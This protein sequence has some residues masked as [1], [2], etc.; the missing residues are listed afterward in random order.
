MDSFTKFTCLYGQPNLNTTHTLRNLEHFFCTYGSPKEIRTDMRSNLCVNK[1]VQA[2]CK[3]YG[4]RCM[5]GLPYHSQGRGQVERANKTAR[6]VIL[7]LAN[8]MDKSQAEVIN[9][10]QFICNSIMRGYRIDSSAGP[11]ELRKSAYEMTYGHLPNMA[12]NELLKAYPNRPDIMKACLLY[13]SP[14]PRD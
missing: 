14:S 9:L 7:A 1:R 6:G 13:T 12:D 11:V 3:D 4:A 8:A 5:L 10:A 2:L